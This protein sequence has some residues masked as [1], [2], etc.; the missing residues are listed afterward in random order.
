MSTSRIK[1]VGGFFTGRPQKLFLKKVPNS[2]S[3]RGSRTPTI[4][5]GDPCDICGLYKTCQ[6]P[7]MRY[8]GKGKMKI[9]ILTEAPGKSE[10]EDWQDLGYEEPTQLIGKAGRLLRKKMGDLGIDIDEDC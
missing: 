8:T 2:S 3:G 4:A 7:K 5:S 10:D 6:S 1:E 9:L